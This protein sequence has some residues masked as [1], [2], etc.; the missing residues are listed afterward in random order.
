[1]VRKTRLEKESPFLH[2]CAV[3]RL[4]LG[5]MFEVK[6]E[7]PA[8]EAAFRNV[9]EKEARSKDYWASL[10]EPCP[11]C[12]STMRVRTHKGKGL[13]KRN[14]TWS[15]ALGKH[16]CAVCAEKSRGRIAS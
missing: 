13:P 5:L 15:S 3:G 16:V 11:K 9:D 14:P 1:M 8:F 2:R 7:G 6:G 10:D 12:S 4:A